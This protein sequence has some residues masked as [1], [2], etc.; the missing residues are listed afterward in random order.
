V[1]ENFVCVDSFLNGVARERRQDVLGA[2]GLDRL[3]ALARGSAR[4]SYG[5]GSSLF[6]SARDA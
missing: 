1:P 6:S 4:E 5:S 3:E 2:R